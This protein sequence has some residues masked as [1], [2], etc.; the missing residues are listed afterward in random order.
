LSFA[1]L[2]GNVILEESFLKLKNNAE[3]KKDFSEMTNPFTFAKFNKLAAG[4]PFSAC[5]K[6]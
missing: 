2:N 4:L 1:E 3:N 6:I 5:L